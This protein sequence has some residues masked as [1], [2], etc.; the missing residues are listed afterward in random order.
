LCLSLLKAQAHLTPKPR[1]I[2]GATSN[3]GAAGN[4]VP[5]SMKTGN[6]H[7]GSPGYG[8]Y[9]AAFFQATAGNGRISVAPPLVAFLLFRRQF[10]PSLLRAGIKQPCLTAK[11]GG[12][13]WKAPRPVKSP[14]FRSNRRA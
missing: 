2:G 8:P 1:E 11:K 3:F 5:I 6:V 9:T 7:V 14:S 12:S 4:P 13:R 10:A